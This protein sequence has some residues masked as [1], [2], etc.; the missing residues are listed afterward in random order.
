MTYT[1][2][3]GASSGIGKELAR[4]AAKENNN[5]V[6]VARNK[7][8][9][10][11]LAAELNVEVKIFT[12]DLSRPSEAEKLARKLKQRNLK[13]KTLINNAG[14][15]DY[16]EFEKLELETTE[17]LINLN[18]LSLT[19]LTRLLLPEITK[20]KGK[21]MNVSSV[22]GFMPGPKMSTYFASK[23]YVLSFSEALNEEL[24]NKGIAVTCLCPGPTKT[25]FADTAKT[26]E[27]HYTN[28]A[29]TSPKFV[30]TRGW[31]AMKKGKA[32][33]V[34]GLANKLN[35]VAAS[36]LPRSLV[37]KLVGKVN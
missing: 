6:L 19:K 27:D 25:N 18:I 2:I 4:I 31:K 24:K 28:R 12:H 30:A 33:E 17:N 13:I 32:I 3:T 10:K 34:P 11:Y 7:K 23:A 20:N 14:V 29:L 1:L 8:A 36:L 16:G 37:R 22:A 9:L 26:R 15:G 5:L 21:I 35:V